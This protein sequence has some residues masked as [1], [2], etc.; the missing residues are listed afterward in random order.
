[1]YI[2]IQ[3]ITEKVSSYFKIRPNVAVLSSLLIL[4]IALSDY[5]LTKLGQRFILFLSPNFSYI[6]SLSLPW[7]MIGVA[8][9]LACRSDIFVVDFSYVRKN[10]KQIF[11]YTLFVIVGLALFVGLGITSYFHF[12]KYPFIFFIITPIAEELIFR[13]WMYDWLNK[14]VRLSPVLITALLFGLHH[15]QY[16]SYRIVPFAIFQISYT[17]ILGLFFGKIRE[18]SGNIYL[19]V[20]L[21]VL[22]N[23]VSY[24]F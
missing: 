11:A 7:L 13:G 15:W 1:M 21:H 14:I 12:V 10:I 8:P 3:N 16:F 2:K 18:K 6:W 23:Y 4:A 19:S 17:F 22:I 9:I 20:L 5:Q 24:S